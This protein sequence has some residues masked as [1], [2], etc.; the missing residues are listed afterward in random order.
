MN[1]TTRTTRINR[2]QSIH[3]TDVKVRKDSQT[4]MTREQPDCFTP[5]SSTYL[6]G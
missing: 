4:R 1:I 2:D 3:S 6:A 5:P